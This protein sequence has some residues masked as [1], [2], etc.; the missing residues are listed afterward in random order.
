MKVIGSIPIWS[1]LAKVAHLVEHHLAKVRVAGSSPVFRSISGCRIM[2]IT[3][4]FQVGDVGSIPIIR[5]VGH[6]EQAARRI[7]V[8]HS[9]TLKY[10]HS[11][12]MG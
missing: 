7:D 4:S 9:Q 6:C 8:F 2:V 1:T 11:G 12:E 5:S 3:P 10:P